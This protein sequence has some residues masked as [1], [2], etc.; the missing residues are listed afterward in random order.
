MRL[1]DKGE[2]METYRILFYLI[3]LTISNMFA[4]LASRRLQRISDYRE[5][6]EASKKFLGVFPITPYAHR[7]H[8]FELV[9]KKDAAEL[10]KVLH[11][12]FGSMAD[13]VNR[14][15]HLGDTLLHDACSLGCI[16]CVAVLLMAGAKR[17]EN[18]PTMNMGAANYRV[19]GLST[20]SSAT[21][22]SGGS[23]SEAAFPDFSGLLRKNKNKEADL[24][25]L[26]YTLIEAGCEGKQRKRD[27]WEI[28]DI[29]EGKLRSLV[30]NPSQRMVR[31][32]AHPGMKHYLE[33][34]ELL[35]DIMA[36]HKDGGD[37]KPSKEQ[38]ILDSL[39]DNRGSLIP[40]DGISKQER[41]D[42]KE[43]LKAW[44]KTAR[45]RKC[46]ISLPS[47]CLIFSFRSFDLRQQNRRSKWLVGQKTGK[48]EGTTFRA[49]GKPS[50]FDNNFLN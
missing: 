41:R 40:I 27:I 28:M 3:F 16:D 7:S 13:C 5:L 11:E 19:K 33:N 10:G 4:F 6:Y 32:W 1:C 22:L 20:S 34:P 31:S 17:K 23:V 43:C 39:R 21:G 26:A 49:S 14:P 29:E 2:K 50:I 18:S 15:N 36:W 44:N 25:R 38:K 24:K 35:D 9:N 8:L 42:L 46:K 12:D 48:K 47:N 37:L 45:G 30:D